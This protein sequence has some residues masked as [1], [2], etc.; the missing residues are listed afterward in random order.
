M[1]ARF[2]S[3]FYPPLT[4]L[5]D[6]LNMLTVLP[7]D[8]PTELM[9]HISLE[10]DTAMPYPHE[11]FQAFEAITH[12]AAREVSET[13]NIALISFADLPYPSPE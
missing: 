10:N 7:A 12:P 2:A 3:R 9:C 6:L 4:V 5:G 11:A 8:Q 1:P 13:F